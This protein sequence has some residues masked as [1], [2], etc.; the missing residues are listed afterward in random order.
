M[1][2]FLAR[3]IF[4]NFSILFL[5]SIA[6]ATIVLP[7][8]NGT[9]DVR[10]TRAK[11]VDQSRLDELAHDRRLRAIMTSTFYP[12]PRS[13]QYSSVSYMPSATALFEDNTLAAY[14]VPNATLEQVVLPG[15]HGKPDQ[16]TN[17]SCTDE[18][19]PIVLF[20]PGL[21]VS[22]LL[23]S[24]VAEAVATYGYIVITIDHPYDADVVEFPN[25]TIA[26][27]ALS[28]LNST[29]TTQEQLE[30][31]VEIRVQ[32]VSFLLDQLNSA[33]TA[34]PIIPGVKQDFN[35]SKVAMYGHSLGGATAAWA[36]LND[37]R[38][39]GGVNIDGTI[40]GPVVQQGLD[41][42]FMFLSHPD[43]EK[44]PSWIEI[45]PKL[46]GWK[47]NFQVEGSQHIG[48]MDYPLLLKYMGLGPFAANSSV[49]QLLGTIDGNRILEIQ[50]TYL[51][52]F[53]DYL[54]KG[55]QSAILQG[56][57]SLYPEVKLVAP[58]L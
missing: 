40:R 15:Y 20:S 46:R 38:I 19:Y 8:G 41:R 31:P 18:E 16:S 44:D 48:F 54:M 57:S 51:I 39:V 33:H 13:G 42:P 52:A 25:G 21:T 43:L 11:L 5:F 37:S 17:A 3:A 1:N 35:A 27:G 4:R 12:I 32:D 56:P 9:H 55:E 29:N 14:G 23:Y 28:Y 50:T 34:R 24:T 22:R 49:A 53:F 47:Q 26:K 7:T 6:K 2:T 36:I 45:W 58:V 10:I 30:K